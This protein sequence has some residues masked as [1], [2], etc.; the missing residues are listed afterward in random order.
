MLTGDETETF[1]SKKTKEYWQLT[2]MVIVAK[3]YE[4]PA[5]EDNLSCVDDS[6]TLL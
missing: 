5:L 6:G 3:D 1:I 4:K 2:N